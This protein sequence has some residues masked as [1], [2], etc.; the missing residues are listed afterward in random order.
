MDLAKYNG[1]AGMRAR[2]PQYK[3]K[4]IETGARVLTIF[5]SISE[6][7]L[8]STLNSY[9]CFLQPPLGKTVPGNLWYSTDLSRWG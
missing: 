1:L 5:T 9:A 6:K 2:P 4:G 8:V 3:F 7:G